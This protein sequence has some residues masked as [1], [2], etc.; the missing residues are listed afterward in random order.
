MLIWIN[1][2]F[3]GG[4]TATAFELVHRLPDAVVCDPERVGFGLH[5]T[6]PRELRGDFQDLASW[7]AG[8]VEVLDLALRGRDGPVIA[9]MTIVEPG[10]FDEVVG[11]LRA[12]GHDVRHVSLMADRQTVLRRLRMRGLPGLRQETFAIARLD[13]CLT[14]LAHPR[15][16]THV[17]TV[18]LSVAEVA[19]RV[20][21]LAGVAIAP[22]DGRWR[23]VARR[24]A[25]S[26]RHLR[27]G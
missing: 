22:A 11:G 26:V 15:F 9:P 13:E 4:K 27:W 2:P 17:D 5:A 8:V 6:M 3:G 18:G 23:T 25:T 10:Y 1:G 19:D 20:A 14:A 12:R 7:R 21:A 24:W 16:A